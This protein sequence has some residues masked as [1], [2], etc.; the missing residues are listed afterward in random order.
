MK[1]IFERLPDG[2]LGGC[3]AIAATWAVIGLLIAGI[4]ALALTIV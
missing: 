3:L 1:G 2:P 4:I